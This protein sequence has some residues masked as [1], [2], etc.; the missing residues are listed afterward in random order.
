MISN[1]EKNKNLEVEMFTKFKTLMLAGA[2]V[3]LAGCLETKQEVTLNPDGSG[4]AVYELKQPLDAMISFD[5]GGE[6]PKEDPESKA[7]KEVTNILKNSKGIDAW[8]DVSYMVDDVDNT[9][10]FKGTAYFKSYNDALIGGSVKSEKNSSVKV[11]KK[12]IT[13]AWEKPK[14]NAGMPASKS[15]PK[16]A[17]L[18]DAEVA[19][20]VKQSQA[21]LRQ[22]TAMMGPMIAGFKDEVIFH[23]PGKID[24]IN[25]FKKVDDNTVSISIDGEKML[26]VMQDFAKDKEAIAKTIKAGRNIQK[27]GPDDEYMNKKIFGNSK[28]IE[29]HAS[30]LKPQ[31]DYKKAVAKAKKNFPAM[32]KKLGVTIPKPVVLPTVKGKVSGTINGEPFKLEKTYVQNNI[33]H[34]RQGKDFFADKEVLIFLFLK[35]GEKLDGKKYSVKA[36]S[37]FGSPHIHMKYKVPGGSKFGETEMFM[38][39]YTMDLEFG[40]SKDG[41]IKGKISLVVPAKKKSSISGEFAAEIK[42]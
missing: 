21:Q 13:V 29:A 41:A 11:D 42:K 2:A 34:L 14:K 26:K 33:L 6:K 12:G 40:K 15:T 16:P 36:G 25:N 32:C 3:V 17:K 38:S 30:K 1:L 4:K 20:K 5:M 10:K 37:G 8:E 35:D 31:F 18:S 7:K 28:P 39:K 9:L 27:D 24:K 23:L 22:M 19:K